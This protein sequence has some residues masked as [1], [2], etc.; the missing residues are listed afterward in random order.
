MVSSVYAPR[1]RKSPYLQTVRR[2]IYDNRC[3]EHPH[4]PLRW[5]IICPP[6]TRSRSLLHGILPNTVD[7]RLRLC[8]PLQSWHLCRCH[9]R[10][11]H[12]AALMPAHFRISCFTLFNGSVL[13][14]IKKIDRILRR[15][16][17]I[18]S[19]QGLRLD[20]TQ[21]YRFGSTRSFWRDST[22]VFSLLFYSH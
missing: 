18:D 9:Y 19:T 11:D 20:L 1:Q 14:W 13:I 2:S 22:Y 3:P 12:A 4:L 7:I 21:F 6:G 5:Y 16:F 10:H 15:F 17:R 8:I